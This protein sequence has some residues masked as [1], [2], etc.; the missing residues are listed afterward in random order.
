M[1][2][3]TLCIKSISKTENNHEKEQVLAFNTPANKEK[4][5]T[6]LVESQDED[7]MLTLMIPSRV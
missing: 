7:R 3:F 1:Q 5:M 2:F 6:V 4:S